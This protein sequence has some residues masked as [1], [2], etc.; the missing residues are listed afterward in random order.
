[1]TKQSK[2]P[3]R[4]TTR[5]VEESTKNKDEGAEDERLALFQ[6]IVGPDFEVR[7]LEEFEDNMKDKCGNPVEAAGFRAT[8]KMLALVLKKA[9]KKGEE[10]ENIH[11]CHQK[12][13]RSH[14]GHEVPG[15]DDGGAERYFT[16]N[17]GY[18]M[19]CLAKILERY[20]K[21]GSGGY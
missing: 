4:S 10:V 2:K 21:N 20:D 17:K 15:S 14:E 8:M 3:T 12:Y 5:R 6:K 11:K 9:M 16:G 1:M 18:A 7:A 13:D 19:Q